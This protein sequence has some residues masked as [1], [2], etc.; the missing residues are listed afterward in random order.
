VPV[1]H[2][3]IVAAGRHYGCQV[4]TCQPFDPESKGGAEQTVKIAKADLVPTTANLLADYRSF[5]ELA[6]ACGVTRASQ[7][8]AASG[9]RCSARRPV[10]GCERTELVDG[11]GGELALVVG[12]PVAV[13]VADLQAAVFEQ[14]AEDAFGMVE[15]DVAE[16]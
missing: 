7:R 12:H 4:Q 9:E 2:P 14:L 10:S 13:V 8:P 1:R 15:V 3:H 5:A 16:G 6:D 11:L